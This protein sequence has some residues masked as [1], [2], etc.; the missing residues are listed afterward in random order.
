MDAIVVTL[1]TSQSLRGWLNA[2]APNMPCIP[3]MTSIPMQGRASANQ[4]VPVPS[5]GCVRMISCTCCSRNGFPPSAYAEVTNVAAR[6]MA[7]TSSAR[8]AELQALCVEFLGA[9]DTASNVPI[10]CVSGSRHQRPQASALSSS[11]ENHASRSKKRKRT[12]RWN[13]DDSE[14]ERVRVFAACVEFH[15]PQRVRTRGER[16]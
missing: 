4:R 12:R 5:A 3:G 13:L 10:G 16:T 8:A 15:D 2:V 7:I 9:H 6:A 1:E 11:R 14:R